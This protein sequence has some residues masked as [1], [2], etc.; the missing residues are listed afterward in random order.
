MSL[1]ELKPA[2]IKYKLLI[3]EYRRFFFQHYETLLA[4]AKS[5]KEILIGE[6]IQKAEAEK[7]HEIQHKLE[8]VAK[9]TKSV[10]LVSFL[11]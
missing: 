5:R 10:S 2:Y 6:A 7:T 9:E 11:L 3:S 1:N 4:E 8:Q